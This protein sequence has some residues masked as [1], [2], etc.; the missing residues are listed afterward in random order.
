MSY[1]SKEHIITI[2]PKFDTP[3]IQLNEKS[4][5]PLSLND[6]GKSPPTYMVNV[7]ATAIKVIYMT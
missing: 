6:F 4:K 2:K 5:N 3:Y 7:I 1:G